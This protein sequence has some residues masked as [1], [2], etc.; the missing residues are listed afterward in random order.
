MKN[1][2][3]TLVNPQNKGK[4]YILGLVIILLSFIFLGQIPII[5]TSF[6]YDGLRLPDFRLLIDLNLLFAIILFPFI[7]G[8]GA[9]LFTNKLILRLPFKTLFTVRDKFDWKRFWFSFSVWGSILLVFFII[10]FF[11][12]DLISFQPKW[13]DFFIL[14][15]ISFTILPIQTTFEELFFRSYLFKTFGVIF[16][17][18]WLTVF[19]TGALFGL[20][21]GAN[22][23]VER[24]GQ[25]LL[26]YYIVHGLFLGLITLMDDGLEL[27][28][29]YHAVNNIFASL[30]VT[31]DWQA[32]HTDALF[33]DSSMPEF[34]MEHILTLVIIQP[35]LLILFSKKYNW[36]NWKEKL[37]A[38]IEYPKN[39]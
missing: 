11:T 31:N 4:D 14:L 1:N 21:H 24:I 26:V 8:F 9:V 18:G 33:I 35:L 23:E 5:F 15:I 39:D 29:G 34:G 19:V 38:K 30:I 25:I 13:G 28:M 6:Y 10:S 17:R 12:S 37:F 3:L 16:K 2:F 36:K 27:T 22:P 32:F 20:M 7:V